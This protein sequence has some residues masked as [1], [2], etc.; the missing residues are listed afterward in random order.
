MRDCLPIGQWQLGPANRGSSGSLAINDLSGTEAQSGEPG[1]LQAELCPAPDA[2]AALDGRTPRT[3]AR[4]APRGVATP[5]PRLVARA[6]RWPAG[7]RVRAQGDLPRDHL[8]LHLSPTQAHHGL[9]LAALSAARQEQARLPRQA[10]RQP[11]KLHRRPCIPGKT[12]ARSGRPQRARALG[13]RPDDVLEIRSG[14]ADRARAHLA[15]AA[16]HPPCQQGRAR[17]RPP[18]RGLLRAPSTRAAPERYLRQRHRV[19]RSPGA[20]PPL[21]RDLLLRSPCPLAEGWH[22]ERHRQD[23]PLYSPQDGSRNPLDRQIPPVH[24]RLQQHPAQMP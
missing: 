23:A 24:R 7:P 15:A 12:A 22:R 17:C 18:S 20:A 8:P 9:Q 5:S 21:D 2:S 14:R 13:G 16:R 3:G 1:R 6:G 4:P 19:R 11:R 10:G